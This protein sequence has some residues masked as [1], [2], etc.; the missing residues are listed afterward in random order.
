MSNVISRRTF[1]AGGLGALASL[2]ALPAS[3]KPRIGLVQSTHKKL[4]R[5]FAAE[6]ELDYEIV[7]EMVWKAIE[8]G[9]PQA[10]SLEAKIKPGSWVV[11]KPNFCYLSAQADYRTGDATDQRVTRAV[12]EYVAQKSKAR[13]ITLAEGGSFRS[14]SDPLTDNVVTQNGVRVD[15][16]T[17]DWGDKEFPG[18]GGTL[19]GMLKEFSEKYPDKRFD[20]VDLSYDVVRDASGKPVRL[21]VPVLNGVGS[22]S[23]RKEYFVTNTVRN[24]DFLISVPVAKVHLQCGV[25]A[26]F[27]NYVGTAPRIAYS[28]PNRFWNVNLHGEHSVDGRIDPF[29]ADLAAFHPPD[30]NVVDV[31]RGLQYREHNNG[32]PDQMIRNNIVLAGESTVAVDAAVSKLLGFNPADIDYLHMGAA[33]GLGSFNLSDADIVGDELDRLVKPFAKP[34]NWYARCNRTWRVTTD[35]ASNPATWKRHTCFGDILYLAKAVDAPAAAYSAMAKVRAGGARKGFLWLG[36]TG[37]ASVFLNGTKI[38][39]EENTTRFRVGQ[40][41]QPVELRAGENEILIRVEQLGQQA[42]QLAAVLV[43]PSNDGDSL[44]GAEWSA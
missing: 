13:R 14:L 44:E 22:F 16:T 8:Y 33:R 41:Q 37:K 9:A 21:E 20:Y 10:G 29:I 31:I 39:E 42:P 17:F 18:V 26:C 27:K 2:R 34:R 23:N 38:T 25:T 4:S 19:N 3:G 1:A 35:P 30:Y 43:G 11:I 36:L 28:V 5:Q 15:A 7:R 6:Q 12:F 40:I 32:Q 24:C